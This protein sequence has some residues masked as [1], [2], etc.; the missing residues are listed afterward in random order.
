[1]QSLRRLR[2][3]SKENRVNILDRTV[4]EEMSELPRNRSISTSST[5]T[6]LGVACTTMEQ[7]AFGFCR[8]IYGPDVPRVGG[9]PFQ[10]AGGESDEIDYHSED[11][12]ELVE[13]NFL[14]TWAT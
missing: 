14:H 12:R 3:S 13:R 7:V 5:T 6:P 1:M 10:V 11:G 4:R 2:H 9:C 8:A